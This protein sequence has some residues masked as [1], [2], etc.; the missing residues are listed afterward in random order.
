MFFKRKS[1]KQEPV[2]ITKEQFGD[3]VLSKF[4]L[5]SGENVD[6]FF[7]EFNKKSNVSDYM[8]YLRYHLFLSQKILETRY[9]EDDS[10]KIVLS[11]ING[12]VDMLNF[13]P[14]QNKEKAKE[15]FKNQ[16]S[17]FVVN[18]DLDITKEKDIHELT[19]NFLE[20]WEIDDNF[21]NHQYVFAAFSLFI[22]YHSNSIL[23]DAFELV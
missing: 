19:K 16:Y 12:I 21:L 11:A 23:T 1:K 9:L 13:F 7:N 14:E 18:F 20:E 6:D 3:Y 22:K 2:R 8:T 4:V 10:I 17:D 15:V 5:K